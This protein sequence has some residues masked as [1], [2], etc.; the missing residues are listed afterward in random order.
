MYMHLKQNNEAVLIF[1]S[2]LAFKSAYKKSGVR[3]TSSFVADSLAFLALLDSYLICIFT[4]MPLR[5]FQPATNGSQDTTSIVMHNSKSDD[6]YLFSVTVGFKIDTLLF[7][8][9]YCRF[10]TVNIRSRTFPTLFKD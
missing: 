6:K 9:N 1:S 3:L 8:T 5:L 4:A 2:N 10:N 7:L